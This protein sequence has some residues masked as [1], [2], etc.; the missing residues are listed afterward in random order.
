MPGSPFIREGRLMDLDVMI[1]NVKITTIPDSGAHIN[2]MTIE[3]LQQL[4]RCIEMGKDQT[5]IR[6]GNSTS[7][8]ALFTVNVTCCL[9]NI[10]PGR[11]RPFTAIFHVFSRLARGVKA[12]VGHNFLETT[13]ALT[14]QAFRLKPRSN[15]ACHIPRCMSIG[16]IS[17]SGLRLKIFLDQVLIR[18][19][20]DTGSE[21][22]L[23]SRAFAMEHNISIIPIRQDEPH[24][25]EFADGQVEDI[26]DKVV[27]TVQ[28]AHCSGQD[29]SLRASDQSHTGGTL[30]AAREARNRLALNARY[31]H[32]DSTTT[33]MIKDHV[34][35]E[36]S[37]RTFY[38]LDAPSHEVILGQSLL[39]S[40]D[41]WNL[42]QSA[43]EVV[44]V[45]SSSMELCTI[46]ALKGKKANPNATISLC[47]TREASRRSEVDKRRKGLNKDIQRAAGDT[48]KL[49]ALQQ[50]LAALNEGDLTART[51][52]EEELRA[53][54]P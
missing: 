53:F 11:S 35:K 33:Q 3:T 19:L 14:S 52:H 45:Q 32:R 34:D 46:F 7:T 30:P 20:P 8:N 54:T 10:Y 22:N 16:Q 1:N 23:I 15:P 28:A 29:Q 26:F 44:P 9:P 43:F 31:K 2:A 38:V 24:R 17:M 6:M 50:K 48:A 12:I 27:V 5:D 47:R 13:E 40:I 42:H 37:L 51:K 25:V 41:A 21:I 36:D 4:H 39:H 18:A 49:A